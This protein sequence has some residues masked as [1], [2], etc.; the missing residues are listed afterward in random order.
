MK[1]NLTFYTFLIG[2][3]FCAIF[4]SCK[5][6]RATMIPSIKTSEVMNITPITAICGGEVLTE[7]DASISARGVCWSLVQNPTLVDSKTNDGNDIGSFTSILTGLIPEST[8]YVRS[9]ATNGAG[10][11]Y[12]EQKVFL[13]PS[14]E[15][16]VS[17]PVIT[18][19][20][21]TT[22]TIK[23][24]IKYYDISKIISNGVCWGTEPLLLN[25]NCNSTYIQ[26]DSSTSSI[27]YS[28]KLSDL[29][30]NTTY[31]LRTN[32]MK[33]VTNKYY[34]SEVGQ[35]TTIDNRS[36]SVTDIDGNVYHIITIGTQTWMVENLKTKHYRNGDEITYVPDFNNWVNLTSG[37][38]GYATNL[39]LT[40]LDD[41]GG[42]YNWYAINDNR[43]IAPL[44][45]HIPTKVE[46]NTLVDFL[47]G[48]NTAG[49]KLKEVGFTHWSIPNNRWTPNVTP[50]T[51]DWGF[52]ALPGGRLYFT[53]NQNTIACIGLYG[54]WWMADENNAT[55]AFNFN[56]GFDY[57]N[58]FINSGNKWEG[59]S[60]RCIKD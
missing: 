20:T 33:S 19:V 55:T 52:T 30:L 24:T 59:L 4:Y 14:L 41:Y 54:Y 23:V 40:S 34:Y 29:A 42:L 27:T 49:V 9:Y 48:S 31:F 36:P 39:N 58:S 12:G 13:T 21:R 43:K 15:P 1:I 44:G 10:T 5:K 50:A 57:I 60:V 11:V 2:M 6:N 25:P 32:V 16:K 8:Y 37:A 53:G 38:L 56:L 51:N 17:K 7:G 26:T 47:G 46:W 35:F 3:L 22:A 18:D 45:W 28:Y